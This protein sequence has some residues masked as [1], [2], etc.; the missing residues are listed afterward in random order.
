MAILVILVV[1][2]ELYVVG[3]NVAIF[4]MIRYPSIW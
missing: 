1:S 2:C 3:V 4:F